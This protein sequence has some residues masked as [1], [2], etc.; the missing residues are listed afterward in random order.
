MAHPY[1]EGTA[2]PRILAH[3]GYVAPAL[4]A[5]GIAENTR[6]AFTAA[7]DAGA[8]YLESDCR[9]SADGA[10]VLFHDAD[11]AR[12]TGE[13]RLVADTSRAELAA[14]LRERG[15]L[16][17]LD[18]ALEEYP[19]ARFNIDVKAAAAAASAGSS[20]ASHAD[21]VLLTSF[22]D[23][24]R[25]RALAAARERAERTAAVERARGGAPV[26][27]EARGAGKGAILPATSP[28]KSSLLRILLATASG[29][30]ALMDRAFAGLDALQIP[31]RQGRFRVLT[32]RLVEQAHRRGVEVHVWTV[33]DPE[34][35]IRLVGL[36]V[37]GIVTDRVDLALAALR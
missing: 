21:R 35:M 15:G 25:R 3:R 12:V 31:E 14:R 37:D 36:G 27:G 24:V 4:A 22:D 17:T 1:L 26:G 8:E 13:D 16:L 30:R 19:K 11:L 23:R 34:R 20:L 18:E 9:F 28:G 2:H 32:P 5:E 29:S 7:L 10:V 6:A 33:N